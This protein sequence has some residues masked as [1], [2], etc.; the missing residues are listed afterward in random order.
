MSRGQAPRGMAPATTSTRSLVVFNGAR[1]RRST[2][3]GAAD[4]LGCPVELGEIGVLEHQGD[5]GRHRFLG[6]PLDGCGIAI[7]T[8]QYA[9]RPQAF[10]Q[11]PRVATATERGVDERLPGSWLKAGYN[12]L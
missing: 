8:E 12:V 3:C 9:A 4:P 5:V 11:R 7:D 10:D 1:R 2:T 6:E